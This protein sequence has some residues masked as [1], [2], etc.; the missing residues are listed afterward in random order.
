MK[1]IRIL[2]HLPNPDT[3]YAGK[4]IF[5][6]YKHAFESLGHTFR[7]L[8]PNDDQHEMLLNFRPDIFMTSIGPLTLRYIDL[9]VLRAAKKSGTKVFVN[10][11]FWHSPFSALRINE[12]SSL[13]KNKSW[14][15][16]IR[17]GNFG[18]HYYNICEQG[19]PRMEGFEKTTGYK[20]HTILLAADDTLIYPDY[21]KKF[22]ADIS[23]IG[24]YLP[25]KKKILDEQVKPLMKK[26]RTKIYGQDWT[27]HDKALG[28]VQKFGQLHNIP[29]I[30]NLQKPKLLLSDERKIYNSS[31]ICVNV[32]E[33]YQKKFG[34][35]CNERTFKIPAAEGFEIVDRVKCITKYFV[36]GKEIIIADNKSDWL[37]K[38][39]YY[40]KNPDKKNAIIK[41]GRKKVL[42][43]H[44]YH[45]RA[46]QFIEY[47]R[48]LTSPSSLRR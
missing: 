20:H 39:H 34:G 4:T 37:E 41:Q 19:D 11:P 43:K 30:K 15:T 48:Q 9:K 10:I 6:G 7:I 25:G 16:L 12:T 13:S 3:I 24:T 36:E 22:D 1:K 42:A 14:I 45:H 8:T 17:S 23:Y 28:L 2:Y 46:K 44:T 35:D 47:Y 31:K 33:E 32:H 27:W 40:L 26:Y 29:I 38:I 18:D 21:S 5:F